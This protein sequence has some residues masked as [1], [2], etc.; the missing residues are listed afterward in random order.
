MGIS[1]SYTAFAYEQLTLKMMGRS[2]WLWVKKKKNS[3][4]TKNEKLLWKILKK[5]FQDNA[6]ACLRQ[7]LE[8][9]TNTV[10]PRGNG[11][12]PYSQ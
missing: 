6:F 12:T 9:E 1:E 7:Q 3:E 4:K 8:Q 5:K 11:F 10:T 2:P